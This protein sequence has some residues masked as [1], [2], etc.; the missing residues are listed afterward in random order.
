MRITLKPVLTSSA[1]TRDR[2]WCQ[3][4]WLSQIAILAFA[5]LGVT[6]EQAAAQA[7]PQRPVMLILPRERQERPAAPVKPHHK[8]RRVKKSFSNVVAARDADAY[9]TPGSTSS[10]RKPPIGAL[11]SERLPP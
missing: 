6:P 11:P 7:W 8:C 1:A 2:R 3:L 4:P 9:C 10:A 5:V